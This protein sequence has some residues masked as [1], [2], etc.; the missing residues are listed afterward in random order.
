MTKET[1]QKTN[2]DKI[3]SIL[4]DYILH[5]KL[6][7]AVMISAPWG[8]GKT[9]YIQKKFIPSFES[10]HKKTWGLSMYPC[11]AL[12]IS[13]NWMISFII[14]SLI[15][16]CQSLYIKRFLLRQYVLERQLLA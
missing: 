14:S 16:T 8:T 5:D 4:S 3:D 12:Q 6:H 10:Q 15:F 2:P 11:L 9:W 13:R 7:Q 1:I